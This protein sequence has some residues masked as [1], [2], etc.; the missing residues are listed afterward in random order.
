MQDEPL[1]YCFV[2]NGVD[3]TPAGPTP[4]GPLKNRI[5]KFVVGSFGLDPVLLQEGSILYPCYEM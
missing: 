5:L 3:N 2:M 1:L 4:P